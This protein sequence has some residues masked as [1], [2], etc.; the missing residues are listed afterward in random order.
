MTAAEIEEIEAAKKTALEVLLHNANGP[1]NGLP[2]TAGWGYPE[3]YTRDLMFSI[4]GV[5][6]SG[7]QQLIN[8]I[9][10]VLETLAENQTEHGHIVSLVHEKDDRGASDTTPLFLLG[11]GIFRKLTG[12][13]GFLEVAVSKALTWMEYQSPSDRYLIAQQPTSDWRDEQWVL[14]FGLFVNAVTY[15]YLRMLGKDERAKKMRMEIK[16]PTIDGGFIHHNQHEGLDQHNKPYFAFWSY[17]VYH[18]D[19]FDLLGNSIAIIAGITTSGRAEAIINWVEAKCEHMHQTGDLAVNL[20][21]NFFPFT[22]PGDADW[23]PRYE[24]F[25]MPGNYH[26]GGLWPF[27][28]GFYVAALVAAKKYDLAEQKLIELTKL[29]KLSQNP[30]L[31]FGFNEWIKAQDGTVKGV[32]WQTWSAALYLYAAKC[33]QEKS[34]PFFDEMRA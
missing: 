9:R 27:I 15:S 30:D 1:F 33:V 12:E 7:N 31:S 2:R 11:V 26:N 25:N 23:H 10:L 4:F 20:P 29:V 34:T 16:R 24:N 8:S 3:P 21:P 18:S 22:H 32:D 28:C 6:V 17:K 14:G 5:A 19:K 13:A